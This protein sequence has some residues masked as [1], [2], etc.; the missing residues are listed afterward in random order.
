M[1]GGDQSKEKAH[2]LM[3]I[4]KNWLTFRAKTRSCVLLRMEQRNGLINRHTK[5]VNRDIAEA[6]IWYD[7]DIRAT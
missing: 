4:E 2:Q 6:E 3:S 7:S 1:E 5:N